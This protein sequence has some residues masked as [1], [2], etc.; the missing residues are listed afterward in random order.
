M[1][2]RRGDSHNA[3]W[4]AAG[5]DPIAMNVLT[6]LWVGMPLGSYSATRGWSPDQL[7]AA[8][9]RLGRLGWIDDGT[10]TPAGHGFRDS[11][12]TLTDACEQPI[13]E[14]LAAGGHLDTDLE[15]LARWSD[16]CVAAGAFPPDA[17]K[18]AAG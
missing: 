11:L 8:V 14:S 5:L 16:R 3:V 2:E 13:V 12:E 1:R 18:R 15:R 4:V 7:A 9:A 6:E 10:L 17:F